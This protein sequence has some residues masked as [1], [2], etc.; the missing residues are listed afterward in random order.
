MK[1]KMTLYINIY[2]DNLFVLLF[3]VMVIF[4]LFVNQQLGIISHEIE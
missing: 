3:C 1:V 2:C 4:K